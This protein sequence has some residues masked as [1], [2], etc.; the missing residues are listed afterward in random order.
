MGKPTKTA[1]ST[2]IACGNIFVCPT[3]LAEALTEDQ[4]A[5]LGR[6]LFCG[7]CGAVFPIRADMPQLIDVRV[8]LRLPKDVLA[9]WHITQQRALPIYESN[10]V[11]SCSVDDRSDVLTVGQLM[12]LRGKRVLDIGS[13]SFVVPG[14]AKGSGY[15]SFVGI[16]PIAGKSAP[17]FPFATAVGEMLPFANES[18]DSVLFGTSLDHVIDVGRVLR[19]TARVLRPTGEICYWGGFVSDPSLMHDLNSRVFRCLDAPF[20]Y[21]GR[22]QAIVDYLSHRDQYGCSLR[23]ID[24]DPTA[25]EQALVDDFHFR[26]FGRAQ[27]IE[28]FYLAGFTVL[29]EKTLCTKEGVRSTFISFGRTMVIR[30]QELSVALAGLNQVRSE[31]QHDHEEQMIANGA[32][33]EVGKEVGSKLSHVC[34]DVKHLVN[35]VRG[36]IQVIRSDVNGVQQYLNRITSPKCWL[37][38]CLQLSGA[39]FLARVARYAIRLVRQSPKVIRFGI[40]SLAALFKFSRRKTTGGNRVLML[41]VSQIDI[42]PRINKMARSLGRNGYEVEILCLAP[43]DEPFRVEQ[44]AEGVKYVR[45]PVDLTVF[46]IY[47]Q[48][49]FRRVG[50]T[51]SY[52]YIHAHDLTTLW[53]GWLLA[54]A[55]NVPLVYDAHEMWSE[56][57]VWNGFEYNEMS[58]WR[59]ILFHFY[60]RF[61]TKQADVF[62]S[63]SPSICSDYRRKYKLAEKP[64]MIANYPE[65]PSKTLDEA[66][67]I[68]ELCDVST[69]KF[70]TLYLGG[71]NP[72]RNIENV[73]Q[74]HQ[75]LP[76]QCVFVIRGPGVEY[77]GELYLQQARELGIGDRVFVL[78]AV[79]RDEVVA[80]MKGADCGIVML[81]NLCK[82]FYWYYPNKFFEYMLG[83]LPVAVSDFPDVGAHIRRER[84]GVV[85]DPNSPESIAAA[86]RQLAEDRDEA[87]A[88]GERGRRTVLEKYNWE[89]ANK[90][91]ISEYEQLCKPSKRAA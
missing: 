64:V 16:D 73:I 40:A 9:V 18:F 80:G 79:G 15:K 69:E 34:E 14:Y 3:C 60:E 41:T 29:M 27:L 83:G 8:L 46:W 51:R 12:N 82:N 21:P 45:T 10:D 23:E 65:I 66:P 4:D 38:S 20:V 88:M 52:D 70:I 78:P 57:V 33:R 7:S 6:F 19:E 28:A 63:V 43:P 2:S 89:E 87:R 36:E 1:A 62:I 59:R 13:G 11:H 30:T 44:V 22:E 72:V 42:D 58:R 71:V 24:E 35:M 67:S 54:S 25:Y 48:E 55:K 49:D 76:E 56:N 37:K 91:L 74:A 68:R 75:Q 39:W 53:T 47:F 85:F 31:L 77:Y 26:H 86:I 50:R 61:L 32:I 5:R 81:R 84:C 90:R 17:D